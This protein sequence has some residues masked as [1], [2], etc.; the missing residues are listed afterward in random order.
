VA[1]VSLRPSNTAGLG[2]RPDK[3]AVNAGSFWWVGRGNAVDVEHEEALNPYI[4]EYSNLAPDNAGPGKYQ[5]GSGMSY[6]VRVHNTPGFYIQTF[7]LAS[8]F[9]SNS[10]LFGGYAANVRPAIRITGRNLDQ[11]AREGHSIAP[12]NELDLL[13][14]AREEGLDLQLTP[15]QQLGAVF[16]NGDF[17]GVTGPGGAGYGDV[18]ERDPEAVS[19]DIASGIISRWTAEH[20]YCVMFDDE[21]RI[22]HATT[23]ARREQ[24]RK[25]RLAEAIPYQQF[26]EEWSKLCPPEDALTLYGEWPGKRTEA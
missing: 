14:S 12:R 20:V 24:E 22:D 11:A 6:G 10:G 8:R 4:A 9:P 5:G 17:V 16:N 3:D 7:G 25:Q 2:A 1:G 21:Q 15:A 13:N 19:A 23:L 18:L 26:T